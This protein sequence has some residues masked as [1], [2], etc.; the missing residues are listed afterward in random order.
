VGDGDR[1]QDCR[2]LVERLVTFDYPN[3]VDSLT[4][5]FLVAFDEMD[6]NTASVKSG[7]N[8]RNVV[9]ACRCVNVGLFLSGT[10]RRD[11]E[12]GILLGK[13]DD[14]KSITF[15]G[16]SLKRVSPDERSIAFFLLKAH[17]VLEKMHPS[18]KRT[19]D[20]GIIVHRTTLKEILDN[21]GIEECYIASQEF[22]ACS[23][24]SH[25]SE[26]GLFLYDMVSEHL[27]L[28]DY[29]A[30]PLPRPPHPERFI[31]EINLTCDN[32]L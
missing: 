25:I 3:G 20:N 10:L 31:L 17:S 27:N 21:W 19:M 28:E 26:S 23:D 30:K 15:P 29:P 4:R 22:N 13:D 1:F 12:V 18:S 24:Y 6:I 9:V 8:S 11:V 5:R 32:K 7:Q 14:I 16:S 2:D